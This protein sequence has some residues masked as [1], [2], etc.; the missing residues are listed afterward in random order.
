MSQ[1]VAGAQH[2]EVAGGERLVKEYL[3]VLVKGKRLVVASS[4]C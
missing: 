4:H 1:A 2:M 3:A